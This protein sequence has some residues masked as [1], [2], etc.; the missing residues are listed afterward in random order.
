MLA[1][2]TSFGW[3][4][5]P[6]PREDCVALAL[7]ALEGDAL[8]HAD[9]GL[10]N[11]P[12]AVVLAFAEHPDG[13]VHLEA[14]LAAAHRGGSL[15]AAAG[16]HLWLALV[17]LLRSEL[18]EAVATGRQA[19]DELAMWGFDTGPDLGSAFLVS[20]LVARGELAEARAVSDA[21]RA[22]E[23]VTE[24]T[25][26]W[27]QAQLALLAAERRDDE[28]LE[29]A[30][31]LARDFDSHPQPGDG[32]L[33]RDAR[34]AAPPRRRRRPAR[35]RTST[36]SSRWP[37]SGVRRAR[38]ARRCACA[39]SCSTIR[40]DLRE[41]LTFTRGRERPHRARQGPA[42]ARPAP[43]PGP[44]AHRGA[45]AAARGARHRRLVR[46][47][48]ASSR[49]SAPSSPPA[50][51]GRAPQALSGPESLTP[52]EKRI[53]T[54]AVERADQPRHRP[55]AVRDA[56]D[57]RGPPERRLPQARHRLAALRSG[58]RWPP[59]AAASAASSGRSAPSGASQASRGSDLGGSVSG[60]ARW[61]AGLRGSGSAP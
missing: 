44:Q 12:P 21:S 5:V 7:A 17:H 42:R 8:T 15:F 30:E 23:L 19:V 55:A 46:R 52:S 4:S 24:G 31:R 9:N 2:V 53:A 28:A 11:V 59:E 22:P 36:S 49:R 39:A 56:E 25:R 43:A 54:L 34:R 48:R 60:R 6:G 14:G 37:G 13:L 3:A 38:S 40:A 20:A 58:P 27:Y 45:R 10:L 61:Q 16:M 51:C 41:A 1:A 50:A 35:A 29:V 57:G 32:D 33:A 47:A 26:H 18:E